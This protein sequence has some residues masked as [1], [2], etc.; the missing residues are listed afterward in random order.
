MNEYSKYLKT[1]EKSPPVC[2][3][4]LTIYHLFHGLIDNR[5]YST[6][7]SLFEIK[8]NSLNLSNISELFIRMES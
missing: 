3:I 4:N 6:R 2:S 5:Q 7:H 8:I 1:R